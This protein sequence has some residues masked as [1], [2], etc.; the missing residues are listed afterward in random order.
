M[1]FCD[2]TEAPCQEGGTPL[3]NA[4]QP[5]QCLAL[6]VNP[7]PARPFGPQTITGRIQMHIG[8]QKNR[9]PTT[10]PD[11]SSLHIP[12][13][14]GIP[15]TPGLLFLQYCDRSWVRNVYHLIAS[16]SEK[17]QSRPEHCSMEVIV[18]GTD[19]RNG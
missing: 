18:C 13:L 10:C 8:E 15:N 2:C 6:L 16:D 11:I 4:A 12:S 5:L 19:V 7:R 14:G 9:S 3:T 1:R 17:A